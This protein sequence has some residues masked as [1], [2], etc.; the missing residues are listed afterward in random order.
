MLYRLL[1][2]M[3]LVSDALHIE[4]GAH[5]W[6]PTSETTS[7]VVLH[8]YSIPLA[9]II[10][11]HGVLYVYWCVTGHAAPENAWA[12]AQIESEAAERLE[13]TDADSFD[14]VLREVVGDK[15]CA[16]AVASDDRGIIANVLLNPPAN[17]DNVHERGMAEIGERFRELFR[18]YQL[19]QE[20]FPLLHSAANFPLA[21]T[22]QVAREAV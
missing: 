18:E 20:R 5:P 19:L 13:N 10:E 7:R 2:G 17:F 15:V 14:A 3:V 16:F 21:P 9:G 6:L 12:Y 8:R 1:E 4:Q 22:P 11:Q